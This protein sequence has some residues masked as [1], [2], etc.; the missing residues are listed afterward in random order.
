MTYFC[1]MY[2]GENN[3]VPLGIKL[4]FVPTY[5]IQ[6][7]DEVREKIGYE[8]RKFRD[9]EVAIFVHGFPLMARKPMYGHSY[10]LCR[11]MIL[12]VD[13]VYCFMESISV[14]NKKDGYT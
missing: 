7:S 13:D 6:I 2:D 10:C 5:Q 11:R 4:K 3:T 14:H 9:S 12:D 1:R 8:Q